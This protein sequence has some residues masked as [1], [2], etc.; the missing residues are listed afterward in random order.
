MLFRQK[1]QK[2]TDYEP[3]FHIA[4]SISEYRAELVENELASLDELRLIQ[5]SFYSVL[6]QD[7]AL[8]EKME[9]F[10]KLFRQM[11]DASAGYGKVK[12]NINNAVAEA[13]EEIDALRARSESLQAEFDKMT[14]VISEFNTAVVRISECIDK[15]ADIASQT[16]ILA[17]NAS[18]EAA[19]AGEA[20]SGFAVVAGEV[21]TLADEIKLLVSDVEANITDISSGTAHINTVISSTGE[22]FRSTVSD[23]MRTKESFER[24]ASAVS[25]SGNVEKEIRLAANTASK[26]LT[27]VNNAFE[28]IERDYLSVNEHISKANDLGTTKGAVFESIAHMTGQ[29]RPYVEMISKDNS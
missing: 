27:V 4:D 1:D 6:E 3:L 28:K 22:S 18:I 12:E 15:I 25:T 9:S 21:K 14:E 16:N 8:K 13:N 7:S 29:I 19:R 10:G 26:E 17:I 24:I 11:T 2:K 5:S 23:T 20:G